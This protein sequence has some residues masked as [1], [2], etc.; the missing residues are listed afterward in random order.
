M[1][2]LS[3]GHT[4]HI[5][6]TSSFIHENYVTA[7]ISLNK[8]KFFVLVSFNQAMNIYILGSRKAKLIKLKTMSIFSN[9]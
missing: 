7:K 8:Y 4:Q 3:L 1:L 5:Y 6:L 2:I 9:H